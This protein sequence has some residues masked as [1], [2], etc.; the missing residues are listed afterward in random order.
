MFRTN[1]LTS[2][3]VKALAEEHGTPLFVYSRDVL[4]QQA[5][6]LKSLPTPFGF[7]PRFAMKANPHPEILKLFKELGLAI[8]ARSGYE[9]EK[10]LMIF[11]MLITTFA[12]LLPARKAA[13]LDPIE[14]LRTE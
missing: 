4:K 3:Q 10:A 7:T 5:E 8:D 2:E 1:F 9:A 12:G 6:G 11:L 13:K 14:A